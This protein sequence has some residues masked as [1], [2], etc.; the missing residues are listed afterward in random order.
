MNIKTAPTCFGV[1][2]TQ[3]SGSASFVLALAS[4]I[5]ANSLVHRLVNKSL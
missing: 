5:E 1:T 4:K 3:S 2:V